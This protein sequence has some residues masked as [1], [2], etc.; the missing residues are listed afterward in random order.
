MIFLRFSTQ[1][2]RI[3]QMHF[4]IW[5]PLCGQALEVFCGSQL[6]P[7][8]ADKTPEC[9]LTLQCR[10]WGGGRRSSGQIPARPATVAGGSGR[11]TVWGSSKVDLGG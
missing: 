8:F 7:S 5:E 10:P 3:S 11:V 9:F 2:T 6:Y 1:F 4:T